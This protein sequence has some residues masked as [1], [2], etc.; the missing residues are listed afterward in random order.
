MPDRARHARR[1]GKAVG[2]GMAGLAVAARTAVFAWRT[3]PRH[4][5]TLL[6]RSSAAFSGANCAKSQNAARHA[7]RTLCK[8][9]RVEYSAQCYPLCSRARMP[10]RSVFAGYELASTVHDIAQF[11]E[12]CADRYTTVKIG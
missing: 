4:A 1:A 10:I 2:A 9:G 12:R 3:L 8:R 7:G 11:A 5:L 6:N